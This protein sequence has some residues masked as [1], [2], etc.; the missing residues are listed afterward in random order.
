LS[1][2]DFFV[3][4]PWRNFISSE[5]NAGMLRGR[6]ASSFSVAT[7][8]LCTCPRRARSCS[9]RLRPWVASLSARKSSWPLFVCSSSALNR[10]SASSRR[11]PP[12]NFASARSI[13]ASGFGG[14]IPRALKAPRICLLLNLGNYSGKFKIIL[15]FL[16]KKI[17]G[18]K[19]KKEQIKLVH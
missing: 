2:S 17:L 12:G 13:M 6:G 9:R 7:N 1:A 8:I 14:Q 5:F 18:H 4:V 16:S 15:S 10:R 3:A 19:I 11:E